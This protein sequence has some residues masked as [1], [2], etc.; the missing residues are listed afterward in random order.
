MYVLPKSF[1]VSNHNRHFAGVA[2]TKKGGDDMKIR[3]FPRK[4]SRFD[5]CQRK[6]GILRKKRGRKATGDSL[7][8]SVIESIKHQDSKAAMEEMEKYLL[9]VQNLTS[10]D[11][12]IVDSLCR[13]LRKFTSN[14]VALGRFRKVVLWPVA[15]IV[16]EI[17]RRAVNLL[18]YHAQRKPKWS[19]M[20]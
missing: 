7:L 20:S 15:V 13:E 19:T 14:D 5:Q 8:L 17:I 1:S 9:L 11:R 12:A 4:R 10:E 2:K 16:E 3:I 18:I 6:L